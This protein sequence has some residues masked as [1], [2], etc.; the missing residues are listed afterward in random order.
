MN[1]LDGFGAEGEFAPPDNFGGLNERVIGRTPAWV[2]WR[3]V[4][5][6]Q[7]SILLVLVL[8]LNYFAQQPE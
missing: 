1:E 8:V 2:G 4:I 7:V 6:L 5:V 3:R